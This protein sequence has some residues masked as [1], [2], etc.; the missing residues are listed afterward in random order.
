MPGLGREN[1]YRERCLGVPSHQ[2]SQ[3]EKFL[4][5]GVRETAAEAQQQD[6]DAGD[7]DGLQADLG[8]E[9]YASAWKALPAAGCPGAVPGLRWGQRGQNRA[10]ALE[11]PATCEA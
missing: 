9:G 8:L 2:T 4:E 10:L 11:Q 5:A 1:K 3:C 7:P 6:P